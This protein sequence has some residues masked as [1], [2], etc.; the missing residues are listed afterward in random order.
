MPR[1]LL[2]V[3]LLAAALFG[4]GC[5]RQDVKRLHGRTL[6]LELTEYKLHPLTTHLRAGR[7]TIVATNRGK[8]AHDLAVARQG[9]IVIGRTTVI[10]PGQTASIEVTLD[11]GT[12]RLFSSQ[13]NDDALGLNGFVVAR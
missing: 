5:T 4:A 10:D 1:A 11:P 13:S 3:L 6:R 9:N 7:L 12:Y 2:A 8:L